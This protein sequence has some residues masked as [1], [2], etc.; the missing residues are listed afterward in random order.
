MIQTGGIEWRKIKK[1]AAQRKRAASEAVI[2]WHYELCVP[3]FFG[4]DISLTT[5]VLQ[6]LTDKRPRF[7]PRC[8]LFVSKQLQPLLLVI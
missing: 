8:R 2:N 7:V 3:L 1:S 5:A 4:F 6:L